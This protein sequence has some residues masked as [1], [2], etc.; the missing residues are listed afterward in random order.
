MIEF[1]LIAVIVNVVVLLGVLIFI[2]IQ[3]NSTVSKLVKLIENR[4][5]LNNVNYEL[6]RLE[7]PVREKLLD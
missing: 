5:R 7:F 2:W 4:I 3:L 1:L 6:D